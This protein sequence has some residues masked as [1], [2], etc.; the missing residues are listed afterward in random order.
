MAKI[1]EKKKDQPEA[2]S[3]YKNA[4]RVRPSEMAYV[5]LANSYLGI[6]DFFNSLFILSY[7]IDI[8]L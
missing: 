2:I 5:N 8:I 1:N 7:N 3:F 4:T 6:G